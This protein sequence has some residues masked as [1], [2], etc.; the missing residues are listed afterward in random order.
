[1]TITTT[2]IRITAGALIAAGAFTPVAL[3][4][5]E[6]KNEPPFTR[7]VAAATASHLD[8][9]GGTLVVP[10]SGGEPRGEAKSETPFTRPIAAPTVIVR[11]GSGFDWG[12]A[13]IGA[14]A[15]L[16]LVIVTLG[17]A[18]ALRLPYKRG[19]RITSA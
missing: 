19:P 13:G 1:V 2:I 16:G 15:T 18:A 10:S 14:A 9:V 11:A 6:P 12:D 4:A 3:A 17:G 8:R 7:P 5:G